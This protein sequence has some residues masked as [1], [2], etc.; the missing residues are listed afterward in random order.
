MGRKKR[1]LSFVKPFC[2]FCEKVFPNEIVLHQHQKSKHFT[3]HICYKKF[4][5]TS[6]LV[7]HVSKLHSVQ[8]Q[9]V[10]NAIEGRDA[11]DINIFGMNGVPKHVVRERMI[12]GAAKYW[13][14]IQ[15]ERMLAGK[16]IGKGIINMDNLASIAQQSKS[17]KEAA[18]KAAPKVFRSIRNYVKLGDDEEEREE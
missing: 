7:S 17:E 15:R 10:P 3:C 13:T 11:A 1:D 12:V 14:K 9:K 16:S 6:N 18:D 8:L 2:Y 5:T 4:P